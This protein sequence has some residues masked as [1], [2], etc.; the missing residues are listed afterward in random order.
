VSTA[1]NTRALTIFYGEE[2][3]LLDRELVRAL[4]WPGRLV[5]S[6]DGASSSEDDVISALEEMTLDGSKIV[7]ALDNAEKVK[8][9]KGLPAYLEGRSGKDKSSSLVAI[10]R[11]AALPKGWESVREKGRVTE[12]AKFK[13]WEEDKFKARLRKEAS[14]FGLTMDDAACTLLLK[15]Y[16]TD[17]C[18]MANEVRKLTF[19]VERGDIITADLVRRVC[20]QRFTVFPWDVAEEAVHRRPRHALSYVALLFEDKGDEVAVPIVAGMM[21]QVER[22]LVM[23][24]MS[25][26]KQSDEAIGAVLRIHPYVVKKTL[27]LVAAYTTARLRDQMERLCELEVQIKGPARSKRT[28]LELAVLSLA[29]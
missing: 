28:L 4:K 16:K 18:L 24:S 17:S 15:L 6:I 25:D 13:A 5:I 14:N 8:I 10:C 22:L 21:K 29:A 7:V 2:D 26:Q 23:R 27:P 20:P 9:G 1:A 11:A 12:H 19:L 3:Y